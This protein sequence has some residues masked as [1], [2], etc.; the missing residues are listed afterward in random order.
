MNYGDFGPQGGGFLNYNQLLS[1]LSQP[2][3]FSPAGQYNTL[4]NAANATTQGFA[5]AA[6]LSSAN[7]QARYPYE[8]AM[9]IEREKSA[10]I[11]QIL[12]S[13]LLQALVGGGGNTGFTTNFGQG[14]NRPTA[15]PAPDP[16]MG[17]KQYAGHAGRPRGY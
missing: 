3:M 2:A 13:P 11:Q 12:N 9:Q 7:L 15:G 4:Q 1:Q 5:N 10:R 17:E 14:I 6:A 8:A 16:Y